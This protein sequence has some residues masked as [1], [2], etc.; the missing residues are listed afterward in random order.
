[1]T[2]LSK[3]LA[4]NVKPSKK[5]TNK[6]QKLLCGQSLDGFSAIDKMSKVYSCNCRMEG[7]KQNDTD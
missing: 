6:M 5:K 1:M 2:L 3:Q 4:K 7:V